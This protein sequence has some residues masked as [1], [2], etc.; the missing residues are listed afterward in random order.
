MMVLA[1]LDGWG[2]GRKDNTNPIYQVNPK[3]IQYV[4]EHYLAGALQSCGIA[5]GL[6]WNEVGNSEVGHLTIGAGKVIYQ[7]YPRISL[8]IQRGEFFK[9]EVFLGFYSHLLDIYKKRVAEPEER[10]E[11]TEGLTD[12]Q[13][14]KLQLKSSTPGSQS[15]LG[16]PIAMTVMNRVC[17]GMCRNK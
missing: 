12:E 4:K 15:W 8:A 13:V 11:A 17:D 3:S 5:V 6:P 2:I 16:R 10:R 1:I 7:H 9:N 14:E